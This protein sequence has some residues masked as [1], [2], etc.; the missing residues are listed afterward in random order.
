MSVATLS[1]PSPGIID[2][3]TDDLRPVS[4]IAQARLGKRP[5]PAVIWRWRVKGC[6]G[7]RLECVQVSGCWCTT[8]AA[9]AQFV[10]AQTAGA[11]ARCRAAGVESAPTERDER[12]TRKLQAAGLLKGARR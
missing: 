8:A 5:S 1:P 12:T 6:H 10:R 2:P 9:F 7:A 4:E 3:E 11:I